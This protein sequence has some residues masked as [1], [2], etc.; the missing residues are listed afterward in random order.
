VLAVPRG[1]LPV[2]R[3]VADRFCVLL[4]VVIAV[5]LGAPGDPEPAL[6]TVVS[7]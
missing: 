3:A 7:A 1:G 6:G 4:D 5:E 2:G